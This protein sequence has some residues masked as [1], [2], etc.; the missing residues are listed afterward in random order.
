MINGI[1]PQLI[2]DIPFL[3]P[4]SAQ[5]LPLGHFHAGQ[6]M[7]GVDVSNLELARHLSF[8]VL[9]TNSTEGFGGP[10]L[11][12]S[13]KALGAGLANDGLAEII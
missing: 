12:P 13:L 1:D 5:F 3:P 2:N 7:R 10:L 9:T 11:L 4:P 6:V 8:Q